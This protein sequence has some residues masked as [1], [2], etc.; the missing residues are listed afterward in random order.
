MAPK[1]KLNFSPQK[2]QKTCVFSAE[3]LEVFAVRYCEKAQLVS[4]IFD[5]DAACFQIARM[6]CGKPSLRFKLKEHMIDFLQSGYVTGLPS[7]L[8]ELATVCLQS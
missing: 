6:H 8:E 1:G 7:S 3:K 5:E 2:R 4:E